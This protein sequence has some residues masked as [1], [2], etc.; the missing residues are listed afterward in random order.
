MRKY[1]KA[2][3]EPG[4]YLLVFILV[5]ILCTVSSILIMLLA[6]SD[7]RHN[8]DSLQVNSNMVTAATILIT[9]CVYAVIVKR[10]KKRSI[11]K[12]CELNRIKINDV[13]FLVGLGF[14]LSVCFGYAVNLPVVREL[15]SSHEGKI[16]QTVGVGSLIETVICSAVLVPVFEEILFR[17]LIF[18]SLK[19]S[20]S[21]RVAVW[22]QASGFALIHFN[23]LQIIY[24]FLLALI[25]MYF[26]LFF[27][28]LYASIL[29]H[30]T[31]NSTTIF[32]VR[33]VK[34]YDWDF[35]F[36]AAIILALLLVW[37]GFW[38]M[39]RLRQ[40][41]PKLSFSWGRFADRG[42]EKAEG[43]QSDE[44]ISLH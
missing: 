13:F 10:E 9:I 19:S 5:M 3:R 25:F 12:Y 43:S 40:G 15:F 37:A 4:G 7:Y 16:N 32:I 35:Y 11:L 20:L 29:L 27:N 39:F 21:A 17:G 41:R 34:V 30:V 28:S 33:G 31:F 24:T 6:S 18:R 38:R 36:L 23:L 44:K 42:E 26:V 1:F 22:I 8:I 14:L 2:L